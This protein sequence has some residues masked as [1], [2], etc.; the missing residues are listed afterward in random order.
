M[1]LQVYLYLYLVPS[2]INALYEQFEKTDKHLTGENPKSLQNI[3]EIDIDEGLLVKLAKHSAQTR[4]RLA[5]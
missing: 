5:V 4:I 2:D 1:R 3:G